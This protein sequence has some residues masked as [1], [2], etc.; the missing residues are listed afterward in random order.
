MIND[1]VVSVNPTLA[2]IMEALEVPGE[3]KE[4]ES[5]SKV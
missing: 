3:G 1:N 4:E 2:S 5:D